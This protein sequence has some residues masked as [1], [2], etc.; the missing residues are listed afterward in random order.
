MSLPIL[1][2]SCGATLVLPYP[3]ESKGPFPLG[4]IMFNFPDVLKEPEV[5][6]YLFNCDKVTTS[7]IDIST[8]LIEA[9]KECVHMMIEDEVF[10]ER[11]KECFSIN[12]SSD[13]FVKQF[14]NLSSSFQNAQ[15]NIKTIVSNTTRPRYSRNAIE[16]LS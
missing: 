13:N 10:Y 8:I 16:N 2:G 5:L 14:Q 6:K 1:H 11:R 7:S 12:R 4:D 9:S 15:K 3:E